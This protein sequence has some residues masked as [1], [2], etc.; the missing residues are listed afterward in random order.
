MKKQFL[1]F[2]SLCL[3]LTACENMG[4]RTDNTGR[5][6]RDRSSQTVTPGNQGE[7]E[8]DRLT[9]Q[10]IRQA[11]VEDDSLSTNAK[12]IKVITS[13][14]V[15]TLRGIVNDEREK[16][17]IEQKVKALNGIKKVQNELEISRSTEPRVGES[18][19]INRE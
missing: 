19:M 11:I 5:N 14:N 17:E 4:N 7:T 13:N 9:T 8:T 16:N 3:L 12:N 6:A 15:V 2:S 10:R 18:P 1:L